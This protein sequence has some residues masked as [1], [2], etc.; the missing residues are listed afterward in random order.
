MIDTISFCRLRTVK[1]N[2]NL[3]GQLSRESTVGNGGGGGEELIRVKDIV[4]IGRTR[5][6]VTR[7]QIRLREVKA[8]CRHI[9]K[10]TSKGTLRQVLIRVY[11]LKIANL[12]R[13]F[14]HVGIFNPAL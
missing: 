10:L 9:K 12:L 1:P 4:V 8:K 3:R 14:S 5:V 11:R 2:W 6:G 7:R 13:T